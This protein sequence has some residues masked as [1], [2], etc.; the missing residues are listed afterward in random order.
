MSAATAGT[1]LCLESGNYGAWTGTSKAIAV[2]PATGATVS[3]ALAVSSGGGFTLDGMTGMGGYIKGSAANITVRNSVFLSALTID[4]L[5]NANILLDHNSHDWNAVYNGGDN[6]KVRVFAP[7]NS[8]SG[9]TV[10]NSTFRNGNLDG[11]HAGG[12]VNVIGNTFS[13]LCDTGTNHTDNI[14]FEGAT[15]GRIAGNYVSEGA[16]CDTQ[17]ITSF[18]GNTSGLTIEDNVVDIRRPWG[19]EL[20]SDTN[21]IVRRNTVVWHA[22]SDCAFNVACGSIDVNRKSADPAGS[23]TRVYDNITTGVG[24]SNGSTGTANNNVSGQN[25]VYVGPLTSWA[26]FKLASTS[27]VGRNAASDGLNAGARIP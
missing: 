21:S 9:V 19:I 6:G 5:V 26:G 20:Y 14:Q 13:N 18:D 3:M 27:P 16:G 4:G 15:G 10:Q 2:R 12:G 24:F 1:T 17:G 22:A 7:G 8:F 11:V 25:A 23:G